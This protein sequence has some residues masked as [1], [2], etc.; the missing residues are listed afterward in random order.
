[1]RPPPPS[2]AIAS[3]QESPSPLKLSLLTDARLI[4][5]ALALLATALLLLLPATFFE[6]YDY[7]TMHGF[8]RAYLHRAVLAGEFPWWN[9]YTA[10][11]RPFF[12]DIETAT[13]YPPTWLIFPLGI[14]GG[15]IAGVALHLWLALWGTQRLASVLG[16]TSL[17]AWLAALTF[18]GS[19]MLLARLQLGQM[20]VFSA[21]CWLPLLFWTGVRL[22]DTP[23]SRHV[24]LLALAECGCVL[25][26]SPN[27]VWLGNCGLAVF[28]ATRTA[29]LRGLRLLVQNLLLAA[30]LTFCLAAVQLLPFADLIQAGNRP[31]QG[32]EYATR[33]GMLPTTWASLL[34][35]VGGPAQFAPEF[36][37]FIGAPLGIAGLVALLAGWRDRTLRALA[38]LAI[39]GGVLAAG[40]RLPVLGWL[41]ETLPG[42]GAMRYPSRYGILVGFAVLLAGSILL[43]RRLPARRSWLFRSVAAVQLA[44]LVI[45]A[46]NLSRQYRTPST[47]YWDSDLR[48]DLQEHG[49]FAPSGVPP[50][51]AFNPGR[52]RSN[53]GMVEG[54][55]TL[56][57]FANPM[58]RN[59]WTAIHREAGVTPSTFNFHELPEAIHHAGPFPMPSAR[60]VAGWDP[61]RSATIFRN[62]ASAGPRAWL[63]SREDATHLREKTLPG[64]QAAI[65]RFSRNAIDLEVSSPT[66]ATLI[67]AEPAYPGWSA[68]IDGIPAP[69]REVHGWMRG[70]DLP[71]GNTT[72]HFRFHPRRLWLGIAL[73][74]LGLLSCR[75]LWRRDIKQASATPCM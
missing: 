60:L 57:G 65:T 29:S 75:W 38:A 11:G 37:L 73:A 4:A 34:V 25:A 24:V 68:T 19:G 17:C 47:G 74:L 30:V 5:A 21:A 50:R 3:S 44:L 51:I 2:S 10:L 53:S 49:L 45:S 7:V 67:L 1:M 22:Q 20:T 41:A 14:T 70:V 39:F 55:S 6:G 33:H 27:V 54:Y 66:T 48:A 63:S 46:I 23:G 58:L 61:K 12:S 36:N 42:F 71:A 13:A 35:P 9:P 69:S 64:S 16:A 28:L 15:V 72:V 52:V 8:N 18:A 62:P 56:D 32:A 31:L 59:V 40:G 43:S 26:G